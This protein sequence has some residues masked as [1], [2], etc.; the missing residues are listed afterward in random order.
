[1]KK[2]TTKI[3]TEIL[4]KI[5][6]NV[7]SS[8][9]TRDLYSSLLVNRIWC[10]VTIPILWELPLGQEC[11]MHDERLMKKALFIRTYISLQLLSKLIG[12]QKRLE[13]LSIAGNG[14][15]DYN[16]LF[17]AII[18]RKETLKSLRLYSVNFTHCLFLA[19]SFTQ[20]S[21]FHCTYL[22]FAAPKYSQKFIIKILEAA[23]R[24]LKSIHL[25]LY[26]IITFEIF[27]A[28][29]NYCTKIE[30]LTLHNLNPEQVIAMI[31]DNF[32]ELRRFS[33]DSG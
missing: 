13:H 21:G 25:D 15:L 22:K 23:N 10:K 27:S 4:I 30:E 7:Q 12:G 14:Y 16:S 17:W 5:L 19:S 8:R 9:S 29:L 31:N 2:M 32:Y 1:Q 6:N 20:L 24:N 11:Y 3:P 26:P 18:S 28:I 33:F